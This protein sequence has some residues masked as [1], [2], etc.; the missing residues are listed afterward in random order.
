M[1]PQAFVDGLRSTNVTTNRRSLPRLSVEQLCG[2]IRIVYIPSNM[3]PFLEIGSRIGR[4]RTVINMANASGRA[5]ILFIMPQL[6][7]LISL[8]TMAE[9]RNLRDA[10]LRERHRDA[11]DWQDLPAARVSNLAWALRY[12]Q[13]QIVHYA[14]H[15]GEGGELFFDPEEGDRASVALSPQQFADTLGAYQSEAGQPVRLVVL[16]GC[17]TARTA[18]LVAQVSGCAVGFEGEPSDVALAKYFTPNLYAALSDG[19]SAQNAVEVATTELRNQGHNR[20]AATVFLFQGPGGECTKLFFT[21]PT[22]AQTTPGAVGVLFQDV[23]ARDITIKEVTVIVGGRD[24][25]PTET[26]NER[27]LAYLRSLFGDGCDWA[28]VS[29]SL[30]DP[31][32]SRLARKMSILDIFTP[33]PVEFRI[34]MEVSKDGAVKDWWSGA[35]IDDSKEVGQEWYEAVWNERAARPLVEELR[36]GRK[37]RQRNWI[38][39]E[40]NEAGLQP[41]LTQASAWAGEKARNDSRAGDSVTWQADASH[42]ALVQTRF[43]LIGDPG[44]GKSTFLRH[45]ALC[46]AGQLL[47][48]A[49]RQDV[50]AA[51]SLQALPGWETAYTPI[52]IELRTLVNSFP[53]LPESGD[54]PLKLPGLKELRA[55][56]R[57]HLPLEQT[58]DALVD[59][60]FSL[61]RQ[62]KAALLLD[63]LDEV[64]EAS[65]AGRQRQIHAFISSLVDEFEDAPILV[66]ARP[67]AYEQ[68]EW[69]I[70]GFG[71]TR[72]IAL[73]PDRQAEVVQRLFDQLLRRDRTRDAALETRAFVEAL[74]GIPDDLRS[75]PLLLT[76]LA[77]LWIRKDSSERDLPST[78]G[79]LYRRAVNLLVKDWVATKHEDYALPLD[80]DTWRIVLEQAAFDAQERRRSRDDPATVLETDIFRALRAV[81]KGKVADD[82]LDHLSQQAGILERVPGLLETYDKQYKFLHLS[83]QEYLT[84]CEL[85][86]RSEDKRPEGLSLFEGRR[87]P[88]GLADRMVAAPVLWANVL[89]F[90]VDELIYRDR[91]DDA[92]ALLTRC[93]QPYRMGGD[94]LQPAL[95]ALQVAL[96]VELLER[97]QPP[98]NGDYQVLCG[99]AR[100]ILG[101]HDRFTPEQR[102][103]A[104]RLLGS[105]PFPG[106]DK[107]PG[108]ALRSDGLPD[109]EWVEVPK[110]D[111][112]S[113]KGEWTYQKKPHKPLET[114]WIAKYPITCAQFEAFVRDGGFETDRWWYGLSIRRGVWDEPNIPHYWNHPRGRVN[115]YDAVA[116]CRW[117][118]ANTRERPDLLPARLDR[119]QEWAITLPTEQQWEKAARG[120]DGRQYPWGEEYQEGRANIDET[121]SGYEVGPH[122]LRKTSAVGMYPH[123]AP[124]DS[125]YGVADLN[126]NVW[127]WCLNEY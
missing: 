121:W 86:Y 124:N 26:S 114:F 66:T 30:F 96:D 19:R 123:E 70:Q 82:L 89:R 18:E 104:G 63:G 46:W 9:L 110:L 72:L 54:Q 2:S 80:E 120:H 45:L 7:D 71:H 98:G 56:L 48:D 88:A 35:R 5:T 41:L 74:A 119:S 58:D 87:F 20:E 100:A 52:Y 12:Y 51:A 36:E 44:S 118:T 78:R 33:L 94:G 105:D 32:E 14:G 79:E 8:K 69:M 93:C 42:A 29:M 111:P 126:G 15:G 117:L 61:L 49:G 4:A 43:V 27:H 116:F 21:G 125:P 10:L 83:F 37:L 109:I 6:A 39:L 24:E 57:L 102:D 95:L 101:D 28:R 23:H 1:L 81:G 85:L 67:Y 115:W 112:Q 55:H 25:R 22:T 47:K 59:D 103:I 99:D 68:E 127:E 31:Q 40:V 73:D 97:A 90:A 60:L 13:P 76:L 11:L 92:Y 91:T 65:V 106:H 122:Y 77:A 3:P 50:P 38:D 34:T 64:S 53:S 113:G 16:A 108:V 62:G 84:A 17:H 107:R 75:N